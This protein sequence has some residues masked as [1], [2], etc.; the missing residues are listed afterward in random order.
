MF[1]CFGFK[2]ADQHREELLNGFSETEFI[3]NFNIE[4]SLLSEFYSHSKSKGIEFKKIGAERSKHII[5]NR[6]KAA[7]GRNVWGDNAF[8][9]IINV[10][11]AV[12][13]K[14]LRSFASE[15]LSFQ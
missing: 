15:Q 13:Q 4:E 6:I 3:N 5:Q 11:D 12:I 1:W 10:E 2:Y 8:Y 14:T 7:I 9:R